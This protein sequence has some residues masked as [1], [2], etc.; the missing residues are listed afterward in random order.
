MPWWLGDRASSPGNGTGYA[1]DARQYP[2]VSVSH[3]SD[4][5]VFCW[6]ALC[7]APVLLHG[8][9][10]FRLCDVIAQLLCVPTQ[11]VSHTRIV[12]R[13]DE[14]C[15][16]DAMIASLAFIGTCRLQAIVL[17]HILPPTVRRGCQLGRLEISTGSNHVRDRSGATMFQT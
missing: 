5:A 14:K 6:P 7:S 17:R 11:A 10:G 9:T 12:V 3:V 16:L 4:G 13:T 15:E 1:P 8:Q 2:H